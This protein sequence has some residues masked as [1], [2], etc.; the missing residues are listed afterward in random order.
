M[1]TS[2]SHTMDRYIIR[3][4]EQGLREKIKLQAAAE[5]RTLNGQLL[6]LI[7]LGLM[8]KQGGKQ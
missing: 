7:K 4:D 8:A 3:F 2:P 1:S 5:N 6:H